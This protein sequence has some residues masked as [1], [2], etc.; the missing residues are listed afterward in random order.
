MIIFIVLFIAGILITKVIDD[1]KTLETELQN[2]RSEICEK[3][4]EINCL[5]FTKDLLRSE[6]AETEEK[7]KA[8]LRQNEIL[9]AVIEADKRQRREA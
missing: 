1:R 5:E 8:A 7:L 6:K 2:Q 4:I 3:E 9:K